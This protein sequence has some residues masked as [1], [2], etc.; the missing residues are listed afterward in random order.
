MGK[1]KFKEQSAINKATTAKQQLFVARSDYEE[2]VRLYEMLVVSEEDFKQEVINMMSADDPKYG[3]KMEAKA[4]KEQSNLQQFY[5]K[6]GMPN[7]SNTTKK[8]FERQRIDINLNKFLNFMGMMT[9][10]VKAQAEASFYNAQLKQNFISIAQQ[11]ESIK[12]NEEIINQNNKLIE[13]NEMMIELMKQMG[14]K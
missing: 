10:D 9:M 6:Q 5:I 4:T 7:P 13:Q 14:N 2:K 11:D 8:A 1:L 12:Q 3:A